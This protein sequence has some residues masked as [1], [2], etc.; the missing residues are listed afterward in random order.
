MNKYRLP[1]KK[2]LVRKSCVAPKENS[3]ATFQTRKGVLPEFSNFWYRGWGCLSYEI[4]VC[5]FF[6]HSRQRC[7]HILHL[8]FKPESLVVS[9][10]R[11]TGK[12]AAHRHSSLDHREYLQM[13][14]PSNNNTT[15]AQS[16]FLCAWHPAVL[17][18]INL[19]ILHNYSGVGAVASLTNEKMKV[20][21]V[22]QLGPGHGSCESGLN[23]QS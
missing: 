15:Q 17:Y 11:S 20:Q 3:P 1:D 8:F 7:A 23:P 14:K 10:V 2:T 5:G 21:K 22:V 6:F 19:I 9:P 16:T 4:I 18:I 13:K 12:M